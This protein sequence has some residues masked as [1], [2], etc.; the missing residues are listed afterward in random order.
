MKTTYFKT[1]YY[2]RHR[3]LVAIQFTVLILVL[4]MY[5]SSAITAPGAKA[6]EPFDLPRLLS[7]EI[8]GVSLGTPLK[9][10]PDILEKQDFTQTGSTTFT[11]RNQPPGQRRSIYRIEVKDTD[12][13]R[14]ITYHRGQSGGRVKSS[15]LQ[16]K[17]ILADEVEM[18][19][20]LYEL[21]CVGI[22]AQEQSERSCSPVTASHISF[23]QG[24]FLRIR[25][26]V[27][28]QL[29][30]SATATIIAVEYSK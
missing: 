3:F 1:P 13:M 26:D 4:L 22:T 18:A 2:W 15:A 24:E 9:A 6:E 28:V 20:V 12:S 14:N 10:I 25:E 29:S 16:E 17:P 5:S 19:K 23:N 8:E 11:K 7:I 27:G 21:V 30:V